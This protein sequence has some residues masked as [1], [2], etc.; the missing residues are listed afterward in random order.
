M[1]ETLVIP[2]QARVRQEANHVLLEIDGHV[3]ELPWQ[4]AKELGRAL[5]RMGAKAEEYAK[6]A[7]IAFDQA[8][9]LR[10]GAPFGLTSNPDIQ[11]EAA[12]EATSN[13]TLRR[14]MPGGIK[15]EEQLGVPAVRTEPPGGNG[16][17]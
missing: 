5:Y 4:K 15:S 6:H 3:T 11:K 1:V 17:V 14:Q 8:I 10:S 16:H 13:R 9:L 7:Q 2:K 12:I